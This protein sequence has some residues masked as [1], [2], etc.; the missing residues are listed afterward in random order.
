[1]TCY[2]D[3]QW[4]P[5]EDEQKCLYKIHNSNNEL[6]RMLQKNGEITLFYI[7]EYICSDKKYFFLASNIF[8]KK[9][10]GQSYSHPCFQ[11]LISLL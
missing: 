5:N 10:V 3:K 4:G 2:I 8:L 1:M 7:S 9:V 11:Y 6:Y